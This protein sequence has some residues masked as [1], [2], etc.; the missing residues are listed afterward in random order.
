MSPEDV[1][2][3]HVTEWLAAKGVG[4]GTR[5]PC[6]D[7]GIRLGN[8]KYMFIT[9]DET[10]KV[11]QLSGPSGGA[12]VYNIQ[13]ASIVAMYDKTVNDSTGAAQSTANCAEQVATMGAFLTESGY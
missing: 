4:E 6:G 9:H 8:K 2:V 7:A 10:T 3:V 5:K 13:G 1:T 12:A 11:T